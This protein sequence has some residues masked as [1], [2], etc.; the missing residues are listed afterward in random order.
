MLS[1]QYSEKQNAN[2]PPRIAKTKEE[3]EQAKALLD[4][5]GADRQRKTGGGGSRTS[6]VHEHR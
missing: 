5:N 1:S 6:S 3:I 4:S 2:K